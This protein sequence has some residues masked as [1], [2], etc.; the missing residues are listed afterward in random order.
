M[1]YLI[2][3]VKDTAVQAFQALGQVRTRG[4]ANRAFRDLINNQ[5][6]KQMNQHPEDFELYIL[7]EY[8]DQTGELAP[9]PSKPELLARGKD[10]TDTPK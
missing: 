1:K 6:N 2:V 10:V 9:S 7:G 4:E 5:E 3:S 8:D